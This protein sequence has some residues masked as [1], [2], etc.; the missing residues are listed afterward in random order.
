MNI[1]SNE[2]KGV[3]S[4]WKILRETYVTCDP[5][6]KIVRMCSSVFPEKLVFQKIYMSRL[7]QEIWKSY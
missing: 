7:R 2:E 6:L 5:F 1:S 3:P 4:Y